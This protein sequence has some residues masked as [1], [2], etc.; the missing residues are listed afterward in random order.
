MSAQIALREADLP[1][2]LASL[3]LLT[4]GE[5]VIVEP[6]G[7]GNINWVRR[8]RSSARPYSVVVKQARPA[9][10]RFPEYRVST[11]RIEFEA[12]WYACVAP[13]DRE[14]LCPRV[15]RFDAER[16]TLVLEDLAGAERLDAVLARG[17]DAT[18]VAAALGR[19]LGAVHAGTRDPSLAAR[20][21]NAEMRALHGEH[22]FALPFRANDFP[23][24][25]ALRRRASALAADA[26]LLRRIDAAHV[27]YRELAIAL[28]HADVQPTNVLVAAGAPKL[29]DAEIAHVGDPAFE[30]GQ[31]A[32]NLWLR[33]LARG[34]PRAA[35]PAVG[36]LWSAYSGALGGAL[37]VAFGDAMLHA[38]VEMLRRTLGAA[39]IPE[40]ASDEL[41]LRAVDAGRAWL[42]A[43]PAHPSLL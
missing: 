37:K 39:R 21:E 18:R 33:A 27:R 40:L 26:D 10:E 31:L 13:F 4:P 32:G 1:G 3:G 41:A 23:L 16:K 24:S 29:L 25:P 7:E 5:P 42:L 2:Y 43:P 8:V 14:G 19:F 12:R 36:A 22:I 34:D 20:F 9:L 35:A 30:I 6:A 15:H 11:R 17:D 38:G 28:V